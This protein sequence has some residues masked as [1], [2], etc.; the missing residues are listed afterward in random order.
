MGTDMTNQTNKSLSTEISGA[1]DEALKAGSHALESTRQLANQAMDQAG[2]K[3]RDLRYGAGDLARRS[4]STVSDASAAAQ[5]QLGRYVHSTRSYVAEEPV[6]S[7]LI[8]A[9][10]GAAVAVLLLALRR[11]RRDHY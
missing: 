5:R 6:K 11:N 3:V 8:A 10:I 7:A 2:E 4:A 1:A 9:A